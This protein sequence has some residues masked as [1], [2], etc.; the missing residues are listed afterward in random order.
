MR[1]K[2]YL[3]P[4]NPRVYEIEFHR[5]IAAHKVP[6]GRHVLQDMGQ[7]HRVLRGEGE[8]AGEDAYAEFKTLASVFYDNKPGTLFH[9]IWQNS[10]AYFVTLSLRQEPKPDFIRYAFEFWECYDQYELTTQVRTDIS[11]A[12]PPVTNEQWYSVVYGDTLWGISVRN[13]MNLQQL[14]EM[15]PQIKNPN[16]I[17]PGDQIR[18]R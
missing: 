17:Y 16:L 15:N 9:P 2:D 4:H 8:F 13:G 10:E 7:S 5:N 14:L 6:F 18:I 1:F 3:W 12:P 11:V